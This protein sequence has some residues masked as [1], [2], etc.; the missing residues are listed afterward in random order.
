MRLSLERSRRLWSPSPTSIVWRTSI[1]SVQLLVPS[2]WWTKRL[3]NRSDIPSF[4]P[5]H[6]VSFSGG[7]L[8]WTWFVLC[9]RYTSKFRKKGENL[10]SFRSSRYSLHYTRGRK[11]ERELIAFCCSWRRVTES[12]HP[13]KYPRIHSTMHNHLHNNI[14]SISFEYSPRLYGICP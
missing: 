12:P 6:G 11:D 2:V 3:S 1:S 10:P 13:N 14:Y 7:S 9:H 5:L 8:R 4:L